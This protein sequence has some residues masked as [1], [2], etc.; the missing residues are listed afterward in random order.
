[1]ACVLFS[2]PGGDFP[3]SPALFNDQSSNG[4]RW[5]NNPPQLHFMPFK[6]YSCL[7]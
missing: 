1:M 3:V 5:L 7:V 2:N 4:R 6:V